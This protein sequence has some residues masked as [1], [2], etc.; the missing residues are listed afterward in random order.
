[1]LVDRTVDAF[2]DIRSLAAFLLKG[3]LADRVTIAL[4]DISSGSPD[5][6]LILKRAEF[7]MR[8]SGRADFADGAGR[9]HDVLF[10]FDGLGIRGMTTLDALYSLI[11]TLETEVQLAVS[12]LREAVATAPIHG[13]LIA[14]RYSNTPNHFFEG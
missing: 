7:A 9:L 12:D 5:D 4:N 6:G 1:M 11:E 14:L 8:R 2:E 3:I 13:R 10:G